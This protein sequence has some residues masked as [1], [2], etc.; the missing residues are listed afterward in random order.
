MIMEYCEWK[1]GGIYFSFRVKNLNSKM[2]MNNGQGRTIG[3]HGGI[4]SPTSIQSLFSVLLYFFVSYSTH[5]HPQLHKRGG[6]KEKSLYSGMAWVSFD[7]S[8][9]T[10]YYE[11]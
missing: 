3:P 5:H 7:H 8:L 11:Y 4:A 2:S 1:E 6:F 9:I 10:A